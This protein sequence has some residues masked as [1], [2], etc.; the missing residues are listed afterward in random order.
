VIPPAN[1]E[2]LSE[3]RF[4]SLSGAE[5]KLL[6]AAPKGETAYCG[7]SKDDSDAS[8]DAA[9]LDTWAADRTIRAEL[10]RWL[11]IDRDAEAW[12][13]PRGIRVH[14]ALIIGPLSLSY[15]AV[16]FPLT[17]RHCRLSDDFDLKFIEIP[18]LDLGGSRIRA[19][20]ADQATIKGSLFL[21]EGFSASGEVQLRGALIGGNLSCD[22]SSFENPFKEG[23]TGSGTALN[24]EAAKVG[25][26]VLLRNKFRASG[27]VR[28]FAAQIGGN[29]ECDGGTFENP[30][31]ANAPRSGRALNIE[32]AKVG[33]AV[34]LRSGFSA[35]GEVRLSNA[36]IGGNLDCSDGE[37]VNTAQAKVDGS[38]IALNA[39]SVR[40]SRNVLFRDKFSAKG[41]VRLVGAIIGGRLS[42]AGGRFENPAQEGVAASGIALNA[43]AAKVGGA[44]LLRNEFSA[45]G[46]VRLFAAQIGGNLEC[47][48]GNFANL[49][50][51]SVQGSGRAL[52]VDRA[53]VSGDMLLRNQ[54]SAKGEVRLYG[55]TIGGNLQCDDGRLSN[56]PKSD[57]K[58]SGIALEAGAAKI[59][60]AVL[61]RNTFTAEGEVRLFGIEIGGNLECDRGRFLNPAKASVPRSGV[62]LNASGA[63]IGGAVLL[64]NSF[65]AEGEVRL[66]HAEIGANLEC[67]GGVFENPAKRDVPTS[68][69]ALSASAAKVAGDVLLR[70]HFSAQGAVL[71]YGVQLIGNLVCNDS[72]FVNPPQEGVDRSGIA[73]AAEVAKVGGAVLLRN[74]FYAEG[75]VRLFAAHIGR[76]L[77]CSQ[78]N[79]VNPAKANLPGSGRALSMA[80]AKVSGDVLLGDQFIAEGEV[81]LV[82]VH[83]EGNVD[84]FKSKFMNPAQNKIP[85]SGIALN[86]TRAAV[87]GSVFL[88]RGFRAEGSVTLVNARIGESLSS[89]RGSFESLDLTDASARS[90]VDDQDS[91]PENGKLSLDGF[92]YERFSGAA[93]GVTRRLEWLRRQASFRRQPYRQLADVL[94]EAGDELGSRHVRSE[95]QQRAWE[96][97]S[98]ITRP[99]SHLLRWTIGYGYFPLRAI[100]CL[101]LVVLVGSLVYR[102][103]YGTGSVVPTQEKAYYFFEASCYP[104]AYY[105]RFH[106]VAY[107]FESSFPLVKLGIQEKWGAAP[108]VRV[109]KCLPR[110][111]TFR[112]LLAIS[113]PGFLRGFRLGQ[114]C[115]GWILT[116]L[117]VGGVTGIVRRD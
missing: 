32:A 85:A 44:V 115:V 59:S 36:E 90:I 84:C 16:R 99:F 117:F 45:E 30:I 24:A 112:P 75:E 81:R 91:W 46:E 69:V 111:W 98:W 94:S 56:L 55:A 9:D 50:T 23:D 27:V 105:E 96:E 80:A 71:L 7:P 11:C 101:L 58:G 18:S 67:D 2:K 5:I 60:G 110:A 107:S 53:T 72:K 42:C 39:E 40:V 10:I 22:G 57:A 13:D 78:G 88:N 38:G 70:N 66:Y 41:E 95:M 108:D 86:A 77:E 21:K 29:L 76:N 35:Y 93:L 92:S 6:R 104:P 48:K 37:F 12:I 8:N 116:T 64:R 20:R 114:I 15:I 82:G 63:K 106:S 52:N 83:I 103:G 25:G 79:F 109:T 102:L 68:G 49:A 73:L 34:F 113:S 14:A 62:T 31:A 54:F 47:D 89:E 26:A 61:F 65:T 43:E 19:L 97:R 3:S 74:Q 28:L 33:G 51:A 1:L 87:G 4:D 17:L 100:W